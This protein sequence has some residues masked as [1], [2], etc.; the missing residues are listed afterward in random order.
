MGRALFWRNKP[1]V[2]SYGDMSW[3]REQ[4]VGRNSVT[5]TT[6]SNLDGYLCHSY[7]TVTDTWKYMGSCSRITN[8]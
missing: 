7:H 6:L 1:G 2:G 3:R 5:H 4:G 8:V